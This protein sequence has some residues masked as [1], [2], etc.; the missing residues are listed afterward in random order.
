MPSI[1]LGVTVSGA[2]LTATSGLLALCSVTPF[3]LRTASC[4]GIFGIH[5]IIY[6]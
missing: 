1:R 2:K 3:L 4:V 5:K 6:L